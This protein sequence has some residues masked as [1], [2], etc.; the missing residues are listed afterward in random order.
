MADPG[1][2]FIEYNKPKKSSG[3]FWYVSEGL[4]SSIHKTKSSRNSDLKVLDEFR[5]TPLHYS[6]Y[7]GLE[8]MCVYF[9]MS[10]IDPLAL[11]KS[12]QSCYHAML[13]KGNYKAIEI[14]LNYELHLL[15]R[16][17]Y[18][19]IILLKFGINMESISLR[20]TIASYLSK[21][22]NLS[23][24][25]QRPIESKKELKSKLEDYFQKVLEK[26]RFILMHQD[27]YKRTGLHYLA[28]SR[29][30]WCFKALEVL[31]TELQ[32]Q[33]S[34]ASCLK[35]ISSLLSPSTPCNP[36][37]YFSVLKD[38]S[39]LLGEE[40]FAPLQSTFQER[41]H[42][43]LAFAVN[44]KDLNGQ[45]PL[46]IACFAGDCKIVELLMQAGG[47]KSI[48]D[49]G[50]KKPLD[51]CTT[52][53]VMRYLGDL[54][55]VVRNKEETSLNQLVSSG[56]DVNASNNEF[57]LSSMHLA[58]MGGTLLGA[59]L[60]CGGNVNA[61][62]WNLYTPLHY[63]CISGKVADVTSLIKEGANVAALSQHEYT[64][65]HL[66]ARYNRVAAVQ[67]LLKNAADINPKDHI[68]RTPLMLSAKHGCLQVA[69]ELLLNRADMAAVDQR[70]WNALHYASFHNNRALVK[71]LV[72]WD[73]DENALTKAKNSQ[74]KTP[75][76]MSSSPKTM[77]A[78][79]SKA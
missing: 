63:A 55:E 27:T 50:G 79:E 13:A 1:K 25:P 3:I 35:E 19:W 73:S 52:K 44:I 5:R 57:M 20:N 17:L 60:G 71:L 48:R 49:N 34:F 2:I 18:E 22:L 74:G 58:V 43:L 70:G 62:E 6:S 65:I 31:V 68:G 56:Y 47:D 42:R 29:Y 30:T 32:G 15:R 51:L 77:K 39:E 46:H 9:L 16:D 45:T 14:V 37:K 7:L 21:S 23:R 26:Y 72:K 38:V 69:E 59:V 10:G 53:L 67:A 75:L 4:L 78:F 11:D 41:L 76:A 61:C 12:N 40:V 54:T 36:E 64:P 8:A 33:D 24:L 66:A 28:L